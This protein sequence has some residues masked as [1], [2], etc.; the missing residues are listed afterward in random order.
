MLLALGG[1]PL[2]AEDPPKLPPSPVQ[3]L[4]R[5][6]HRPINEMSGL[7][8]SRA[9]PDVWWTHNDSG[10]SARIFALD[11][12][13]KVII[14]EA[15]R[16]A[17][18]GE[19]QVDGKQE[20]PGIEV[21]GAKNVD[22]ED[23]TLHDG[24][25]YLAD[26]GNNMN[27]RRDLG[28]YVIEEPDPRKDRQAKL[29]AHWRVAYPDQESF[30]PEDWHFDCESIFIHDGKPYV[31]TKHRGFARHGTKPEKG[32][33]LY[34]LDT[35][36]TDRVNVLTLVDSHKT[37]AAWP[38]AASLSPDGQRLAVLTQT[39]V[40]VFEKPASGDKWLSGRASKVDLPLAETLQ[41]EGICWDDDQT[42][43]LNQEQR[44]LFALKLSALKPVAEGGGE[45]K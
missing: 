1:L 20:W 41:A 30:P 44:G 42:L 7:A 27:R 8:R 22:W 18:H 3:L 21:P 35:R 23:L 15:H 25:L 33:K 5:V 43:R 24:K 32:T 12:Q 10:D 26:L 9:H 4:A 34:R 37:I 28:I 39:A 29:L 40:W 2:A 16:A 19:K 14:P 45:K 36:H 11:G 13:G 17:F 6:A 38:T 31:L